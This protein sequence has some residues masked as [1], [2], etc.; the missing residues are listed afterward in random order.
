M[1]WLTDVGVEGWRHLITPRHCFDS[2]KHVQV[3]LSIF[4]SDGGWSSVVLR[5]HSEFSRCC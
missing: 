1:Y 4:G 3:L 2:L 5:L